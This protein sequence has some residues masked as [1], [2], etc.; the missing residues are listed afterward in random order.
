MDIEDEDEDTI[1]MIEHA[2]VGMRVK[3]E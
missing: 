1:D 2:M 3:D